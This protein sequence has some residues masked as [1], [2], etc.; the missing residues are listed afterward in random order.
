MPAYQVVTVIAQTGIVCSSR[1]AQAVDS[2]CARVNPW[3]SSNSVKAGGD[4]RRWGS[5]Y[6]ENFFRTAPT[7]LVAL[8]CLLC[9]TGVFGQS[10]S[11]F[12]PASGPPG[13]QVIITGSGFTAATTLVEFNSTN[14]DFLV[15]DSGHILATVPNDATTGPIRITVNSTTGVSVSNFTVPPRITDFSP[16]QGAAGTPVTINGANFISGQTTVLFHGVASASVT[17]TAPT[18][19]QA[20]PNREEALCGPCVVQ[21]VQDSTAP[22]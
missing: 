5:S 6:F 11:S 15:L 7:S 13:T 18:Q 1:Y 17:V 2:E 10:V 8:A 14:A 22:T 16:P 4:L 21:L 12:S 9:V 19:L 20:S 3:L